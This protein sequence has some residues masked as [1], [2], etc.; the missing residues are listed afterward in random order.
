MP[1]LGLGYLEP[2]CL[3]SGQCLLF[4]GS[5]QPKALLAFWCGT[6]MSRLR[7]ALAVQWLIPT[8]STACFLFWD[9]ACL[10]SRPCLLCSG[11]YR[12]KALLAF[13]A[14]FGL[15]K[16]LTWWCCCTPV[17]ILNVYV[18]H[19]NL[20]EVSC[21]LT[22]VCSIFSPLPYLN[23]ACWTDLMGLSTVGCIHAIVYSS[24]QKRKCLWAYSGN[25]HC[26]HF[27]P[28]GAKLLFLTIIITIEIIIVI[29]L[30]IIAMEP[31]N[32]RI[33]HKFGIIYSLKP[34]ELT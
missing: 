25:L 12:L 18:G 13:W 26:T 23:R 21:R 34:Y 6:L 1:D 11:S 28:V 2:L 29:I 30:I 17:K 4:S 9:T 19:Q 24:F 20:Q 5:Y 27:F 7:A 3:V 16:I 15:S 14:V 10:V 33:N 32:V 31:E 22:F 8:K